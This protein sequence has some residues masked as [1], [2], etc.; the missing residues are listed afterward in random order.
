MN[1]RVSAFDD[2]LIA[3]AGEEVT[4]DPRYYNANLIANPFSRWPG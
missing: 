2:E 3:E 1:T 4:A